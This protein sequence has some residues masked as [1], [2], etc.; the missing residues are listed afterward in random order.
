MQSPKKMPVSCPVSSP[1]SCR[2]SLTVI[3]GLSLAMLAGCAGRPSILP[4]DDKQLRKTS[5][6]FAADAAKRHPFKADAP[7]GGD[8]VARAEVG[9][10]L[11]QIDIVN[12]SQDTWNDV[13][14]WVN[15]S[16]VVFIPVMEPK[17]LKT[18]NFQMMFDD[19]GNSFPTNNSKVLV[20][21]VEIYRDGK[22]YNVPAKLGD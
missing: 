8:A 2:F 15:Q 16:Y 9:Y 4:N 22:M 6:Q 20:K 5:A 13:E 3:A 10:T 19:Q 11:N 18:L 12:L 17:K 21:N 14:V 7:K 1:V